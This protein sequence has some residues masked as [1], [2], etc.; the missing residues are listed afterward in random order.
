MAQ[1]VL[2]RKSRRMVQPAIKPFIVSSVGGIIC[3]QVIPFVQKKLN[4]MLGNTSWQLREYLDSRPRMPSTPPVLPRETLADWIDLDK[5]PG[6]QMFSR[7]FDDVLGNPSSPHSLNKIFG[8][9]FPDGTFHSAA[10]GVVP[11]TIVTSIPGLGSINVSVYE[12]DIGN[13]T[14]FS[15]FAFGTS[16]SRDVRGDKRVLRSSPR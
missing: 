1:A 11:I 13:L 7:L 12:L 2:A 5:N 15:E 3:G 8:G 16:G 4:P 9:L 14:S 10:L 6:K